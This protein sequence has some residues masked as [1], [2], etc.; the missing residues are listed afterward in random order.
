MS[1]SVDWAV[2][3]QVERTYVLIDSDWLEG[4]G[5]PKLMGERLVP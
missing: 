1:N 5:Y 4:Y 3:I 2:L